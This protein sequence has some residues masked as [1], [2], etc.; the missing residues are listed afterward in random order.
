MSHYDDDTLHLYG[1]DPSLVDD[2]EG[3]ATHLRGCDGCRAQR[4]G[5]YTLVVSL[6][7]AIALSVAANSTPTTTHRHACL[8]DSLITQILDF[9]GIDLQSRISIGPG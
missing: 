8:D 3:I 9:F 4:F 6:G 1:L 7:I 5:K 2:A